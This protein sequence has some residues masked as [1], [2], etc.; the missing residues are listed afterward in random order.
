[1]GVLIGDAAGE[2]GRSEIHLVDPRLKAIIRHR[3]RS[4]AKGVGF[5]DIG[6][7]IEELLVDIGDDIRACDGKQVVAAL[8]RAGVIFEAFSPKI[9]FGEGLDGFG[10]V[11]DHG[12]HRAV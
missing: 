3:D 2:L 10:V 11:L 4:G 1:M 9:G 12:S 7:C 8:E 5:E 6:P